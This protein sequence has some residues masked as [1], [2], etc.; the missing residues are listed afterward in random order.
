MALFM[1]MFMMNPAGLN[2]MSMIHQPRIAA[3]AGAGLFAVLV[4]VIAATDFASQPLERGRNVIA[5]LG[6]ELL[7]DSMLV[8]ETAGIVLLATMICSVVLSSRSGRF[9]RA[10][11]GSEPPP[12]FPEEEHHP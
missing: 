5:Q 7:G 6:H 11:E 2:P 9:G 1:I 12:L 10:D 4:A 3:A 8:F